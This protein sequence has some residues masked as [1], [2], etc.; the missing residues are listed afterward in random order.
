MINTLNNTQRTYPEITPITIMNSS[1]YWFS[2]NHIIINTNSTKIIAK[3]VKNMNFT[4]FF[5][6]HFF[7]TLIALIKK[8]IAIPINGI[9]DNT[10]CRHRYF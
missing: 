10:I 6:P 7:I 1:I 5:L 3:T 8:I 9:K 4:L 2:K